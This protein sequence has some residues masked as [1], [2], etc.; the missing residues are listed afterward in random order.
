MPV[1]EE[2]KAS[3]KPTAKASPILKWSPTSGWNFIPI[4]QRQ[5]IDIWSSPLRPRY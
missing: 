4:E 1:Q 2:E 5:W 3:G